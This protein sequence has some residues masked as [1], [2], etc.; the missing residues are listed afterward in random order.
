[1]LTNILLSIIL[2]LAVYTVKQVNCLRR[3]SKEQLVMLERIHQDLRN[4]EEDLV[5]EAAHKEGKEMANDKMRLYR[6][7]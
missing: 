1:M 3:E 5:I 2:M 7:V 4:V 6:S